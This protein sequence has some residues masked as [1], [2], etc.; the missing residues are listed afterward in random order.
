MAETKNII[1]KFPAAGRLCGQRRAER[2]P[3]CAPDG[4][5]A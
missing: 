5:R 4:T 3:E 2:E 1:R